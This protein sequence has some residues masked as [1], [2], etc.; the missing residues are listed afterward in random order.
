MMFYRITR[1]ATTGISDPY[2][3]ILVG[4][5][6][7]SDGMR[8]WPPIVLTDITQFVL[9][10]GDVALTN[11]MLKDQKVGN[12][13]EYFFKWVVAGGIFLKDKVEHQQQQLYFIFNLSKAFTIT[14]TE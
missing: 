10:H 5:M 7:M 12:A 9:T 13:Y 2:K 6:N 11:E 4:L 14:E 8:F 3:C 1:G